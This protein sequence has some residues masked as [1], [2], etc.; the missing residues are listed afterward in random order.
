M[1]IESREAAGK[2][3]ADIERRA[4]HLRQLILTLTSMLT[5]KE[6]TAQMS[7]LWQSWPSSKTDTMSARS[8]GILA[9]TVL[10]NRKNR[11]ID[12]WLLSSVLF[13]YFFNLLR[14]TVR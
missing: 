14:Y 7:T 9:K 1:A 2:I 8:I 3:S 10:R 6:T 4:V 5:G 13:H 12:I 11:Y